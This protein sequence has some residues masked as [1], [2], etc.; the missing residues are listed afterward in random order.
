MTVCYLMKNIL[1]VYKRQWHVS[2]MSASAN[3][4]PPATGIRASRTA[5]L[6]RNEKVMNATMIRMATLR[7]SIM[8]R[9]IWRAL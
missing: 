6:L 5:H 3:S 1:D 7:V 8:S 4:A 9:L 2:D